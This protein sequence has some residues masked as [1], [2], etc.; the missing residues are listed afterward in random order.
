MKNKEYY[1]TK[2]NK[3]WEECYMEAVENGSED[4]GY[5]ASISFDEN[6]NT[7]EIVGYYLVLHSEDP[8]K[9]WLSNIE[10]INLSEQDKEVT[11]ILEGLEKLSDADMNN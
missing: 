3:K 2:Y 10:G 11:K 9:T 5:D 6:A 4:P 1:K 7:E 8:F